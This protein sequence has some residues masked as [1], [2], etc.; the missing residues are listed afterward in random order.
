MVVPS[1]GGEPDDFSPAAD[2]VAFRQALGTY[3]TGVTIVTVPSSDG[4]VGITA[5]SFASV[6]LD[7]PLVLW[8]P[9]RSSRRFAYF[10]DAPHF[11]IHVLGA[12]HRP[13]CEAFTRSR[14]AFD[15]VDWS[16]GPHGVPLI[17]GMAARLECSLEAAYDAGDHLIIIGRVARAQSRRTAPLVFHGGAYGTV[18][19]QT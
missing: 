11:A 4:P 2:P 18:T 7:P 5:N 10:S 13:V 19:D 6:S 16:E 3:A 8:S 12:E 14:S 17:N 1:H 15:A 9:A